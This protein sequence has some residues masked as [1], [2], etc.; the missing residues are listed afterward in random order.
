LSIAERQVAWGDFSELRLA[1]DIAIFPKSTTYRHFLENIHI[2]LIQYSQQHPQTQAQIL[3]V[4]SNKLAA[5]RIGSIESY[6]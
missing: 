3:S 6:I 4:M 1:L 5:I 2:R